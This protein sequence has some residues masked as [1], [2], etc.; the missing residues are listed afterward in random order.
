MDI[1]LHIILPIVLAVLGGCNILQLVNNKQ[2]RKKLAEEGKQAE[3]DTWSQ[4]VAGQT[5]EIA[6]LQAAYGELQTKYFDLAEQMQTMRAEML[7][8]KVKKKTT[9]K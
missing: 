6:R 9:K 4:I 7:E 8:I 5:Q 1:L 3:N 2:L